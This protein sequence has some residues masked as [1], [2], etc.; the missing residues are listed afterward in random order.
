MEKKEVITEKRQFVVDLNEKEIATY[1]NELARVTSEQERL[2][3][4]KK[5]VTSG[6]KDKIDRLFLD[7]RTLARKISTKQEMR[8]I[9]CEWNFNYR[10]A[11]A[12]LIRT[13]TGEVV[14][15]RAMTAQELQMELPGKK[16][17]AN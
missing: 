12:D 17:K 5:S 2:E 11:M 15:K 10:Q 4:E 14:A 16:A 9:D 1:S 7:M 6:Y 3:D 8:D 13:D